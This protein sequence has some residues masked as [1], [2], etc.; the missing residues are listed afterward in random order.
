M[1]DDKVR[2]SIDQ[3]DNGFVFRRSWSHGKG[4][5]MEHLS[6]EYF[7]RTLPGPLKN[8][9]KK[10]YMVDMENSDVWD[11]VRDESLEEPDEE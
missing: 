1:M 9:F 4:D 8:L 10:G 11:E 5:K 7:T 2:V 3:I 6:D